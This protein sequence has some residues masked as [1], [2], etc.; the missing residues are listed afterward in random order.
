M[1]VGKGLLMKPFGKLLFKT[2]CLCF[3]VFLLKQ[4]LIEVSSQK[5]EPQS[6]IWGKP[7]LHKKKKNNTRNAAGEERRQVR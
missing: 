7:P 1:F 3:C 4:N 5:V 2:F 6:R